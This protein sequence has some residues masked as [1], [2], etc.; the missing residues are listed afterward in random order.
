[1]VSQ[2]ERISVFT[3][4]DSKLKRY[5][6]MNGVKVFR[7]NPVPIRDGLDV[8]FSTQ[9]ISWGEG[10]RFLQDLLSLNQLCAASIMENGPFDIC[11]A[12]DWLCLLGGDGGQTRGRSY[13]LP[14]TRPGGRAN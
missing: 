3:L 14:C 12:H 4:G 6:E 11:V 10:L 2:G 13:D 7:M 1:M 5:Q 9:T 8:F